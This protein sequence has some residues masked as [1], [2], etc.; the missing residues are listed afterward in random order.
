MRHYPLVLV[1]ALGCASEGEG[2]TGMSGAGGVQTTG[3]T[4]SAGGGFA[5]SGGVQPTGGTIG[6][7]GFTQL[8]E[9]PSCPMEPMFGSDEERQA[10]LDA[11]HGAP[12]GRWSATVMG[13]IEEADCSG[14]P[15]VG[16]PESRVDL[17]FFEIVTGPELNRQGQRDM[18]LVDASGIT[19]E[20]SFVPATAAYLNAGNEALTIRIGFEG[21]CV[22][23]TVTNL[24]SSSDCIVRSR[25]YGSRSK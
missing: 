21:D 16:D 17:S 9:V 10:H 3:G 20:G 12:D 11:A 19:F 5:G 15:V 23:G 8:P 24:R 7:G 22:T 25:F 4:V 2:P 6:T 1:L 18:N 13:M 14:G